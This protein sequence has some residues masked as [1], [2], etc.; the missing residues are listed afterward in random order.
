M[1]EIKTVCVCEADTWSVHSHPHLQQVVHAASRRS[2]PV[3]QDVRGCNLSDMWAPPDSMWGRFEEQVFFAIQLHSV[4]LWISEVKQTAHFHI[5]GAVLLRFSQSGWKCTFLI[6][7]PTGSCGALVWPGTALHLIAKYWCKF[8]SL[9][10]P[11]PMDH[12]SAHPWLCR[13][14]IFADQYHQVCKPGLF[15]LCAQG[16]AVSTCFICSFAANNLHFPSAFS[17]QRE[18]EQWVWNK[19]IMRGIS[20]WACLYLPPYLPTA[21]FVW[22]PIHPN[23]DAF[24]A[25]KISLTVVHMTCQHHTQ[26]WR[27]DEAI[28]R[29]QRLLPEVPIIHVTVDSCHYRMAG[30]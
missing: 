24:L 29:A 15:S 1:H 20:V 21:K 22:K 11:Q 5:W 26:A 7:Q 25:Y 12:M 23:G 19:Q 13:D 14:H 30:N 10:F 8:I 16:V 2:I 18:C 4:Q 17:E 6:M 3:F 28:K 9:I 27:D